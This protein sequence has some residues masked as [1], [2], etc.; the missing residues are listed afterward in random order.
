MKVL[1][2]IPDLEYGSAARQLSWLAPIQQQS[3]LDCRVCVLSGTGPLGKSFANVPLDHLGWNRWVDLKPLWRLRQ[4]LATYRPD[5]IHCWRLESV[6]ALALVHS[7]SKNPVIASLCSWPSLNNGLWAIMDHR[8]L[9]RVDRVVVQWPGQMEH[10]SSLGMPQNKLIQIFPGVGG[11]CSAGAEQGSFDDPRLPENARVVLCLGPLEAS[12]GIKDAVW[13]FHILGFLFPDL[14]LVLVGEGPEQERLDRLAAGLFP[15]RM[16]ALGS[17]PDYGKI[18]AR[19]EL[20]WV[21]SLKPRGFNVALEAMAAGKPVVA[22]RLPG[23][24]EI[25]QDGETGLLFPTGDKVSLA[26]KTRL[27]LDDPSRRRQMGE[28]GRRRAQERFS[29]GS[30]AQAY[31]KLCQSLI[32]KT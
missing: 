6:R 7:P 16:I 25:V 4:R 8:L 26:K 10:L 19:A 29:V 13:A 11:T 23:L 17:L 30:L 15:E 21:P 2:L 9:R 22:S 1:H 28:A 5:V 31:M 3:G 32:E 24:T 14:Y 18:L 27:I 20:V 12:K